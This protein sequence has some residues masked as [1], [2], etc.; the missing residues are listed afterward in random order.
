MNDRRNQIVLLAFEILD[1]DKSGVVD[2]D[3]I[4]KLYNADKHPD[5][6]SGL[7][8]SDEILSLFL[9]TFDSNGDG[10]VTPREFIEYYNNI[11][12]SIDNDD[13]FELMIRNA[14]HI[15]GGEGWCEN[16]SNR[17]VL[18]TH[19]D[20]NQSV[21][22]IKNDLGINGT[23]RDKMIENLIN[24]GINDIISI[25][26]AGSKCE[27]ASVEQPITA[28]VTT[29]TPPQ[30]PTRSKDNQIR[31]STPVSIKPIRAKGAHSNIIFG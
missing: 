10:K 31:P 23:D 13:Y 28:P 3:D 2:I 18:V 5:V 8:S 20:G 12:C 25:D 11:S 29:L 6:I 16:S 26:I 4:K 9:D 22:E 14:W 19:T 27:S 15:S 17:R 1:C 30:S 24:Q 21:R 7:K